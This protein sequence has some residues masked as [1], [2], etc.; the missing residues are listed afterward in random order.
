MQSWARIKFVGSEAFFKLVELKYKRVCLQVMSWNL[1]YSLSANPRPLGEDIFPN[2][3]MN[4][5]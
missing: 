5:G 3:T 2:D 1:L 4:G